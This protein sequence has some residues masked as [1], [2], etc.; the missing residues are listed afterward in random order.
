MRDKGK[1]RRQDRKSLCK[2]LSRF[3]T[4]KSVRAGEAGSKGA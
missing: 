1:G 4:V 2:Q 3:R